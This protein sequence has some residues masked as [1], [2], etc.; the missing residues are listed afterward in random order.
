ML[1]GYSFDQIGLL[2]SC[3]QLIDHCLRH[4]LGIIGGQL[5]CALLTYQELSF[6]VLEIN[7]YLFISL[8]SLGE[9]QFVA[10]VVPVVLGGASCQENGHQ[11]QEQYK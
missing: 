4:G 9:I 6:L 10:F 3:D 7:G 11:G 2:G 8:S 5:Y 1:R